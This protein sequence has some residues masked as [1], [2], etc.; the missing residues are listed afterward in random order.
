MTLLISTYI[1]FW[2]GSF[3]GDAIVLGI[4]F[5]AL[6]AAI[7]IRR[8]ESFREIGFRWDTLPKASRLLSFI[9][10]PIILLALILGGLLDSLHFP[11]VSQWPSR[12]GGLVLFGAIQEYA[13]L[14]VYYRRMTELL[15]S[16]SA[17]T[18]LTAGIFAWFHVPN[19]LLI[20]VTFF[21]AAFVCRVYRRA[22]NLPLLGV[23]HG[24]ISF[25][26][27]YA[28][29]RDVTCGLRVGPGFWAN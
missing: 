13:L 12:L 8:R 21:A 19:P 14:G 1:W 23:A 28:L 15:P 27:Y 24:L 18:W 5:V 20:F 7:H 29:P 11:V 26:L 25:G 17:S 6:A 16:G 3:W 10:I 4:G 9:V 22:P 2:Q